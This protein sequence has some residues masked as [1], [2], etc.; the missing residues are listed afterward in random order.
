MFYIS[1]GTI[2]SPAGD[3]GRSAWAARRSR[4]AGA[5]YDAAAGNATV[6]ELR[7]VCDMMRS[8]RQSVVIVE[9]ML[10]GAAPSWS[11]SSSPICPI[12]RNGTPRLPG[13]A[14]LRA[15]HRLLRFAE[16]AENG[17][18]RQ[19]SR[20]EATR[21][22]AGSR[23]ALRRRAA[24]RRRDRHTLAMSIGNDLALLE[25]GS[26][27][28]LYRA[29]RRS[30]QKTSPCSAPTLRRLISSI[31]DALGSRRSDRQPCC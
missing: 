12:Y 14:N 9:D 6:R 4:H 15:N 11:I 30:K 3:D 23:N 27:L 31:V 26:K 20:P 5:E 13:V 29:G 8:W 16:K 21:S 24:R 18:A 17:Y 2:P 1:T 22:I 10:A 7:Q 25:G 19:F 28:V